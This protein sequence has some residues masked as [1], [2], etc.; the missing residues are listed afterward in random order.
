MAN[1]VRSRL[2]YYYHKLYQKFHYDT[3]KA[4]VSLGRLHAEN[5]RKKKNI[6]DLKEVEFQVFSQRGEDGIIQYLINQIEIP[7]PIF[8]EFGV[9]DYT[10]SNTRFL[11]INNNW[12]GLV[13]DGSKL[14]INF[15]KHD[16]IYW[17]YDI[18]A[19]HNFI[20][21]DNINELITGYT[22]CDDIGLL[23]IDVDGNDY[24]I[25]DA[26]HV[27]R[28]RIVVCEYNSLFGDNLKVSV[29]YDPGFSRSKKHYS[30]L[31]FGASLAALCHLADKKGY[32]FVG[33]T[34]AGVNAF[35][36][37]KDISGPFVKYKAAAGFRFSPNRDS[38]D[39]KG[40]LTFL[41][42]EKRLPVIKELSLVDVD[43]GVRFLIKDL[44]HL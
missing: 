7:N 12:S 41:P 38:K 18:T 21:K 17:K 39:I 25:W 1:F 35:F 16:F 9:E 2:K 14:N 26:I 43:T 33:T 15:I 8:I 6:E 20:T 40:R 37:R 44:Y 34:G 13:I 23:S 3:I 24:W 27:V 42:H 4:L 31:Y 11:L 10:E 32:D 5:N 19:H 28:P 29:P 22:S 30:N 36:V